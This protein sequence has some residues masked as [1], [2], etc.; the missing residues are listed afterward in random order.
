VRE[1]DPHR[2]GTTSKA[3]NF[4]FHDPRRKFVVLVVVLFR[5]LVHGELLVDV[6]RDGV[7][8]LK[9][10]VVGED[11]AIELDPRVAGDLGLPWATVAQKSE[12]WVHFSRDRMYA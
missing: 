9:E 11:R 12:V 8:G 7:Y 6:A 5:L 2:A 1:T 3:G 4:Q 10:L